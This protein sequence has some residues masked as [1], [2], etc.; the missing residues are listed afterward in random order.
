MVNSKDYLADKLALPVD[1]ARAV[2]GGVGRTFFYQ[3]VAAG[4]I[5]VVKAGRR[6]LV[7]VPELQRW[8]DSL[9]AV[10]PRAA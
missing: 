2:M 1:Q 5:R 6:T 4:N 10:Q 9:P 3:Q 7:P 8:L